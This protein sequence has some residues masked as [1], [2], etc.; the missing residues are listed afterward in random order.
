M[1]ITI[2]DFKNVHKLSIIRNSKFINNIIKEFGVGEICS[3]NPLQ[4]YM[5]VV[6]IFA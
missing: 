2:Y 3:T 4:S 6:F 1:N 5:T